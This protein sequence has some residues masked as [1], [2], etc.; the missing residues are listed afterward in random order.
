MKADLEA[1]VNKGYGAIPN[2]DDSALENSWSQCDTTS[3]MTFFQPEPIQLNDKYFN[4]QLS[5][6]QS[7]DFGDDIKLQSNVVDLINVFKKLKN[8]SHRQND[9]DNFATV[10]HAVV[11][12]L[13]KEMTAQ[14]QEELQS[15]L[16]QYGVVIQKHH[17][18][19]ITGY[20]AAVVVGVIAVA[21][22]VTMPYVLLALL[23]A[24]AIALYAR[25]HATDPSRIIGD[26]LFHI[27]EGRDFTKPQMSVD[28]PDAL[29]E[30]LGI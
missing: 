8:E 10:M 29:S 16:A 9:I 28:T 25:H 18:F 3:F 6:L 19:E 5:R 1:F 13:K 24:A 17:K 4:C 30:N 22:G 23:L 20:I 27:S 14:E 12:Y 7:L 11:P 26:K 21:L 2:L 15:K